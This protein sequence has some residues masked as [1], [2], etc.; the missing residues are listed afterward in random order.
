MSSRV[1]QFFATPSRARTFLGGLLAG[2]AYGLLAMQLVA[3]THRAV[4]IAYLFV[5]PVVLGALPV[6]FST[7]Q[8]LRA[9]QRYILLPWGIVGT[10]FLL[11]IITH[12]DGLLCLFILVGP[13]M[14]LG[15]LGALLVRLVNLR[16]EPGQQPLYAMVWLLLPFGAGGLEHFV[17]A[18]TRNYTVRT[19][20]DIAALPAVVWAQVQSVRHIQPA[21]IRPHLVHLLGVPR[22]LDGRLDFAGVG[23]IRHITWEKGLRFQEQLTSWQPGRGFSYT[24]HVDPASIPP[25]TLDEH[26]LVGG[27]YFD[28]V[29]GS[30][31]LQ[32]LPGGGT[33]LQ[34]S[35]TYRITTNLNGYGRLWADFLLHDF[36]A[37]ILEVVQGRSEAAAAEP[38]S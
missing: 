1:L 2:V 34:L 33:R 7:R 12:L 5:L 30:Y 26:V 36:N 20:Q 16:K 35:C 9:Y 10:L 11:A 24:I 28:V 13:F 27:R 4:S 19:S 37:M 31:A 32:P 23:G 17:P 6:V 38:A 15:T 25:R 21:E 18:T 3:L 29:S 22:P 8:Q 14:L